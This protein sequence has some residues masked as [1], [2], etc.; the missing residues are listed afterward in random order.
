MT[1]RCRFRAAGATHIGMRRA[2]NDDYFNVDEGLG[3]MLVADGVG[4]R[5]AGDVAARTAVDAVHGFIRGPELTWPQDRFE[6]AEEASLCMLAAFGFANERV[7][8][9]AA[10]HE[11]LAGMATTLVAAF[12]LP[13]GDRLVVLHA[14]DSRAYLHRSGCLLQ[15]TRDHRLALDAQ[16]RVRLDPKVIA[17]LSPDLL[18]RAIGI[19]EQVA[20][21]VE[22]VELLPGD[23]IALATDGLTAVVAEDEII[24]VLD[25]HRDLDTAIAVLIERANQRGG[26][27]NVAVC[28]GRWAST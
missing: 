25:T 4:G 26:P 17:R 8:E 14:G 28:L 3:L 24:T 15:L 19:A 9:Q 2:R 20:P 13:R 23:T 21:E 6:D 16:A 27:D 1:E 7:R 22:L 18:T 10:T 11:H 12:A 5:T